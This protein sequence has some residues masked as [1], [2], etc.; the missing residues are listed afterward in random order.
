ME[1]GDMAA[2]PAGSISRDD[3]DTEVIRVIRSSRQDPG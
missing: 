2:L 1:V 3:C